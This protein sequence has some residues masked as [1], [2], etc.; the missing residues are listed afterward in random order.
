MITEITQQLK[1][2]LL[3]GNTTKANVLRVLRGKINTAAELRRQPLE[4][5]DVYSIIRTEA[6]A[7]RDSIEAFTKGNR[8]DLVKI[9]QAELDILNSFL[10]A[11]IPDETIIAAIK[12]A[13]KVEKKPGIIMKKLSTLFAGGADMSKVSKLVIKELNGETN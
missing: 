3:S 9:E 12:E 6:K 5:Q 13:I 7:R 4:L 1:E 8:E 10:P 11:Q 2:A